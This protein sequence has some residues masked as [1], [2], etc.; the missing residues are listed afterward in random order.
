MMHDIDVLPVSSCGL[1]LP[2][3]NSPRGLLF[4]DVEG[5]SDVLFCCSLGP[6]GHPH[7]VNSVDLRLNK[8][9]IVPQGQLRLVDLVQLVE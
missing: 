7:A 6:N 1:L 2:S 3:F 5:V 8:H 9:D 4:E